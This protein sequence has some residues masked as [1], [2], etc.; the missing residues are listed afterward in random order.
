MVTS[1]M[2]CMC[3]HKCNLEL[4]VATNPVPRVYLLTSSEM[5]VRLADDLGSGGS[6]TLHA[7]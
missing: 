3:G 4:G 1:E 5:R 2:E 6:L 7:A